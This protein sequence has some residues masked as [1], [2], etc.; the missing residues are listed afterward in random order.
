MVK[1]Q[2]DRL[3]KALLREPIDRTPVWLMRQAGRYLPEYRALRAKTKDFFTFCQTPELACEVTLQP[4]IRFPLDAAI[5]FSDILTV[6][7][8]MGCDIQ[9]HENRGPFAPNPIRDQQ[10]IDQLNTN[11]ALEKLNYVSEA[12]K[13]TK[14][15][16]N[17]KIPLIGFAG[18]PW[19]V[20]TYMVEGQS[21][22]TFEIIKKMMFCD[23]MLLHQLLQKLTMVTIDY[24]NAQISA[25]ADVIMLFDSWG[26]VLSPNEYQHFS[27]HYMQ[28]IAQH[29]KRERDGRK[30]PLIFFS[31]GCGLYLET[32]ANSGCDAVGIDWTMDLAIA[33]KQVGNH[34]ALQGNL[35][36]CI[37]LSDPGKI[38]MAVKNILSVYK[39]ETGFIFNLGHG[40]SKETPVENVTALVNCITAQSSER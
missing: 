3:I 25:G 36:P 24:I 29:I 14:R 1:L 27:L 7:L 8:A 37:L 20:A 34:V 35:D 39:N 31:K 13:L 4:I 19:T 16:L 32:I 5:I 22:K 6:P 21:S 33:K 38:Q 26:G 12:I 17:N 23:P 30:I 18:S 28:F 9:M 11:H 40:I 15:E 2:N 10:L